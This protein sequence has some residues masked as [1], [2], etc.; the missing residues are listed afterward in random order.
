MTADFRSNAKLGRIL[1]GGM[2]MTIYYRTVVC[3][4]CSPTSLN[5]C[6]R[7]PFDRT[8]SDFACRFVGA[9][10]KSRALL[11][12]WKQHTYIWRSAH[13]ISLV[14]LSKRVSSL[15]N[16]ARMCAPQQRWLH[17]CALWRHRR[18]FHLTYTTRTCSQTRKPNWHRVCIYTYVRMY[19]NRRKI[20]P[21]S[22]RI[23]H[24]TQQTHVDNVDSGKL[25]QGHLQE[26]TRRSLTLYQR[27]YL[28]L[29]L[30]IVVETT[31]SSTC[32]SSGPDISVRWKDRNVR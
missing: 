11:F 15:R 20:I 18:S 29:K 32:V 25:T 5:V 2:K 3:G 30:C 24:R 7:L 19:S 10:L 8:I 23:W 12:N 17:A 28:N 14:A 9:R 13:S 1:V 16:C 4:L 27:I 6:A 21:H 22:E 26:W 31:S